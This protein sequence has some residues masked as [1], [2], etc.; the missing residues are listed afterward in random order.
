MLVKTFSHTEA[1]TQKR[2]CVIPTLLSLELSPVNSQACT[3]VPILPSRIGGP[4]EP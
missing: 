2:G 4:W 3:W 1:Y